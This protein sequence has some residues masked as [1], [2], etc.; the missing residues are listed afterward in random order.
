MKKNVKLDYTSKRLYLGYQE[1]Y[2]ERLKYKEGRV[3]DN[4]EKKNDEFRKRIKG[5]RIAEEKKVCLDRV[6]YSFRRHRYWRYF[7]KVVFR[8]QKELSRRF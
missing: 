2:L 5:S 6:P 8:T 3:S 4:F 1:K 7:S